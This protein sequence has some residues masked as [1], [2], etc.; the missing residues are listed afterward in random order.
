MTDSRL[1]RSGDE[2]R[3]TLTVGFFGTSIMERTTPASTT[4][5]ATR[6]ISLAA[7][8]LLVDTSAGYAPGRAEIQ[9][10]LL[11]PGHPGNSG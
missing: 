2:D 4:T 6:P 5:P 9:R 8:N 7:P 11:R 3:R 1:A 10:F